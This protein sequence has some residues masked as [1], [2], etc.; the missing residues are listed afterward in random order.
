M[1]E[2]L[3]LRPLLLRKSIHLLWG[4]L[5]IGVESRW[6]QWANVLLPLW[7][8]GMVI[9]D[10]LRFVWGPWQT[11][12]RR[13]FGSLLKPVERDQFPT[14]ATVMVAALT[15]LS[16]GFPQPI[17]LPAMLILTIADGLAAVV[18]RLWPVGRWGRGK[19]FSGSA[20]FFLVA[21]AILI[22]YFNFSPLL[23]ALVAGGL[24]II[25]ALAP[26]RWE[27]F[28]IAMGGGFLL[29]MAT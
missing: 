23:T 1:A 22:G 8:S 20:A 25:E 3:P 24:T 29:W 10:I 6:P 28:W 9:A 18:G 4:L 14:G 21:S 27:N 12:F 5:A 16:L 11:L 15:A 7:L 17:A 2:A 26:S 13:L 19:T